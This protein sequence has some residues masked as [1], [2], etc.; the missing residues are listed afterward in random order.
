MSV[1]KPWHTDICGTHCGIVIALTALSAIPCLALSRKSTEWESFVF[2]HSVWHLVA[3]L[4][5]YFSD[6]VA[7]V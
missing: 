1:T 4:G 6:V 2:W 5:V 3:S 7:L